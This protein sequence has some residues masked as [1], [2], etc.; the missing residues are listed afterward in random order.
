MIAAGAALLILLTM[1]LVSVRLFAG[2]T[3]HDRLLA[4][5]AFL[6]AAALLGAAYA[7]AAR[8]PE[9]LDFSI[10]L[11]LMDLPVVIVSLKFL[12]YRTLHT[13]LAGARPDEGDASLF[14]RRI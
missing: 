6:L 4:L 10:V 14:G 9:W 8:Q 1:A 3:I 12:R 11:V 5:H 13:P 7:A 2:P